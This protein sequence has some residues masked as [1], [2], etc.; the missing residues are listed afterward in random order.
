MQNM[1]CTVSLWSKQG[2][3]YISGEY[4]AIDFTKLPQPQAFSGQNVLGVI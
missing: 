2:L 1:V 3:L 4:Q